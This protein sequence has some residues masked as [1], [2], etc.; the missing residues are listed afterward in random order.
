MTQ[1]QKVMC[2]R[3]VHRDAHSVIKGFHEFH[4]KSGGVPA[5]V[6]G[7]FLDQESELMTQMRSTRV[8]IHARHGEFE[9]L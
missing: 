3:K 7:M 2:P 9:S 8:H 6:H 1:E 4:D 5:T